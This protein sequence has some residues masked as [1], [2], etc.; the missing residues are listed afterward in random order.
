[1][2]LRGFSEILVRLVLNPR[3][4][5][6][7][8]DCAEVVA[9][10]VQQRTD[11]GAAL[12]IDA[13]EPAQSRAT[14]QFQQERLRL[15]V[16][17]VCRTAMQSAP[18]SRGGTFEKRVA[19]AARG[20]SDRG[21]LGH[22]VIADRGMIDAIGSPTRRANSLQNA[23]SQ[24][25]GGPEPVIQMRQADDGEAAVF[26]ELQEDA[27]DRRGL[28]PDPRAGPRGARLPAGR[29]WFPP[30][31]AANPWMKEQ[32]QRRQPQGSTSEGQSDLGFVP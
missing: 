17:R 4:G 25:S 26:G 18:L 13:A 24:G 28:P 1:M 8:T 32:V 31:G 12:R 27:R 15:V 10:N 30:D 5:A 19:Q 21:G 16:L 9:G 22:G 7:T 3:L 29:G 23:S 14:Y 11:R 2:R 20:V 6:Q